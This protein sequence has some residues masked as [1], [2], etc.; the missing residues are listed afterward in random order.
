ME[1]ANSLCTPC[2]LSLD[3]MTGQGCAHCNLPMDI[4]GLLCGHCLAMP[5]AHDAVYA[6]VRYG[7][8]ARAIAIR[9]KHGRRIGLATVMAQ[10]MAQH[11]DCKADSLIIP[12][13]L[14]RSRLW[15]RGFNQSL[16]I[17][18][19]L[20]HV[21]P[22]RIA[23]RILKRKKKTPMLKGMGPKARSNA[24]KGAFVL[25]EASRTSVQGRNVI[26]VDDVYTTGAT[27]NAAAKV[28]KKAGAARVDVLCWA[29]V[30][31]E[32]DHFH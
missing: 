28:L 10:L 31:S 5:P 19:A 13:P 17:A 7:E 11:F 8:T 21:D 9:Y 2:W 23:P 25:D 29:R 6:A 20:P 16:L 32:Q 24:L 14:H 22:A 26:L 12:I 27:V 4:P 18:R 15:H 3:F 30:I 1:Q